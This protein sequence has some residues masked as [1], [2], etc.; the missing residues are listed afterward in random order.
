MTDRDDEPAPL[1]AEDAIALPERQADALLDMPAW[2][3]DASA[4]AEAPPPVEEPTPVPAA[5][6]S[7]PLE[8]PQAPP[9]LVRILEAMLFVGGAPLTA[10]RACEIIR[11]LTPDEFQHAIDGLNRTYRAQAR[12]YSIRTQDGGYVLDLRPRF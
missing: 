10:Q 7:R 5:A 1:A 11:G 3:V 8:A 4:P 12:P 6:P 9:P 2:Q